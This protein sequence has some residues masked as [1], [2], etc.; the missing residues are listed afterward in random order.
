MLASKPGES[1][2][3]AP[4]PAGT[5]FRVNSFTTSFQG[6]PSVAMAA[7]GNFLVVWTSG[8]QSVGRPGRL[9]GGRLRAAIQRN[10]RGAKRR[11]PGQHYYPANQN[12]PS[13]AVDANGNYVV[14]FMGVNHPGGAGADIHVQRYSATG[15]PQGGEF[16]V[17]S[18]TLNEQDAPSIAADAAGNFVVTWHSW[19]MMGKRLGHLRPALQRRWCAPGRGVPGQY[20]DDF[21][22]RVPKVAR[23][24]GGEFVI[25]WESDGQ[26]N[27]GGTVIARRYN[28]AGVVQGGEFQVNTQTLGGR[29]AAVAIDASGSFVVVWQSNHDVDYDV[30]ARRYSNTGVAQGAEFRV[31]TYTIGFQ[32]LPSVS[33]DSTGAFLIAWQSVNQDGSGSGV[34][35]QRFSAAG[36]AIGGEFRVNTTTAADQS[37]PGRRWQRRG[38][39]GLAEPGTGRIGFR[40]LRAAVHVSNPQPPGSIQFS[41]ALTG[42]ARTPV[43]R[44][45]P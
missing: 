27:S 32:G 22:Q 10:R 45:S 14:A 20:D 30:Y 38:R 3:Q 19:F 28:A 25:V 8:L 4:Q 24:P 33:F 7:D 11:V 9:A 44:P 29:K 12:Q 37:N 42:S 39:R 31:N 18:Y 6:A 34:Y 40:R 26:D 5:E 36:V 2:A 41:T 35:A 43:R 21:D 17:N 1:L 23:D 16:R 13:A 15:V